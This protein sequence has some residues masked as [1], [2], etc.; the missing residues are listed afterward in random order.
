MEF[1]PLQ[2]NCNLFR[3]HKLN[4]VRVR[5]IK[6]KHYKSSLPVQVINAVS[7]CGHRYIKNML[8]NL[9]TNLELIYITAERRGAAWFSSVGWEDFVREDNNIHVLH[10]E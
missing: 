5:K 4:S 8:H 9:G 1:R 7:G 3:P 2:Q 6:R 10:S